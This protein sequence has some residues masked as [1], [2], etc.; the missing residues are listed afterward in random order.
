MFKALFIVVITLWVNILSFNTYAANKTNYG[1]ALVNK[2]TSIYDADTFKAN[3]KGW[4]DII[5]QKVSIRVNG[6]DA[7]EIRGKCQKEKNAARIAKLF[8]IKA[9]RTAK[10]VELR[11]MRRGKYFRILA[12]VYVDNRNLS[13]LLINSGLARPYDGGKRGGWC[14]F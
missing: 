14:T 3:I 13:D 11:N 8:T 1:S 9:L 5:G 12:D 4:P 7:P 10:T 2:I 6:V